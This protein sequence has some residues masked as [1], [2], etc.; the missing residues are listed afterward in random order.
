MTRAHLRSLVVC[1]FVLDLGACAGRTDEQ[2]RQAFVRA[3]Q[4]ADGAT[5]TPGRR[6]PRPPAARPSD[7]N[8][9]WNA[10]TKRLQAA[11][12]L[13]ASAVDSKGLVEPAIAWCAVRPEPRTT[14]GGNAYTCFPTE[15]LEID[16]R[17]FLLSVFPTGVIGL[18]MDELDDST[19]RSLAQR[20]RVELLPLCATPFVES[21]NDPG[22]A[23]AFFTC[24][25]DGGASLAVGYARSS[26][27][28]GWFVSLSV[29]GEPLPTP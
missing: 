28:P 22:T 14:S 15:P 8:T 20:A 27:G 24:P 1:A 19:A 11:I 13:V 2:T 12:R 25:V 3:G 7:G 9:T 6:N 4:P 5:K 21:P 16:R 26:S 18:Q 10:V 23:R 17:S 29:L